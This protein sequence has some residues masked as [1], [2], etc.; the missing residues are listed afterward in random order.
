MALRYLIDE[1]L[2]GPLWTALLRANANRSQTL[3]LACVGDD[4]DLPLSLS[5]RELLL[6]A[7]AHGFV[8][9]SSDLRTMPVHLGAHL[10]G[11]HHS[12]GV[13]LI[14]L[15][16]SIPRIIEALLYYADEPETSLWRDRIS[17][18]P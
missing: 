18:I 13:F 2:R 16:C 12:E 11:G 4:P 9:V 6:W 14:D 7:E 10:D 5:D 3:E 17:Y 1:N 15:P 8:V